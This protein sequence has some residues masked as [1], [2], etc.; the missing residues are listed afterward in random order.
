M[1]SEKK[2]LQTLDTVLF[3]QKMNKLTIN[4]KSHPK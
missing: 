3:A 4:H 2:R 1:K